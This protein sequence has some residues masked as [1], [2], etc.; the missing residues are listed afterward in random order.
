MRV[1]PRRIVKGPE[2]NPK[3]SHSLEATDNVVSLSCRGRTEEARKRGEGRRDGVDRVMDST[4]WESP[5]AQTRTLIVISVR[6]L[7]VERL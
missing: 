7:T 6:H 2:R 3:D 4:T 1:R 5:A